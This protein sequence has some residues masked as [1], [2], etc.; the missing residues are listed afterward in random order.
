MPREDGA[1]LRAIGIVCVIIS[2]LIFV[3]GSLAYTMEGSRPN[4]FLLA[5][6]SV[7]VLMLGSFLAVRAASI[8]H[9]IGSRDPRD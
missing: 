6:I 9:H 4:S 2:L 5:A 8:R 1:S 7:P 3:G